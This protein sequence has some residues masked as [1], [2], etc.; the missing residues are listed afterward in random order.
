MDM[1]KAKGAI[2]SAWIAGAI[3][4]VITVIVSLKGAFGFNQWNLIDAF[5]MFA[6]AFGVYKKS[7][8]SAILL[9]IFWIG[10]R[11]LMIVEE[12]GTIGGAL[13]MAILFGFW[14][15]QGIRGTFAYHRIVKAETKVV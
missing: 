15:F 2:T 13:V 3:S 6:L 11:I 5:I 7:R 8:I 4:G 1:D 9:F 12:P 10:G 14:F